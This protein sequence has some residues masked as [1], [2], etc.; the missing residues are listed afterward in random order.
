MEQHAKSSLIDARRFAP[1]IPSKA[2]ATIM[3]VV[4]A[5]SIVSLPACR[6]GGAASQDVMLSVTFVAPQLAL[7]H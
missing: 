1:V 4:L 2:T 6:G 7:A 3:S 5:A